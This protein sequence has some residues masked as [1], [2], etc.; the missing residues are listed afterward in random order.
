MTVKKMGEINKGV[1]RK[2]PLSADDSDTDETYKDNKGTE[3]DKENI[4]REEDDDDDNDPKLKKRK[5]R[6]KM[7]MPL[8]N[9]CMPENK[10][11]YCII[12][13]K[14]FDPEKGMN[15]G[16]DE[17]RISAYLGSIDIKY[18]EPAQ[19][20]KIVE[21]FR[22]FRIH[23]GNRARVRII[24]DIVSNAQDNGYGWTCIDD[25]QDAWKQATTASSLD[26][27]ANKL[28]K[29]TTLGRFKYEKNA[30][31][32]YDSCGETTILGTLYGAVERRTD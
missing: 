14:A 21:W 16:I 25:I 1:A 26:S 17:K 30:L 12:S 32:V 15:K 24:Q 18:S 29:C 20:K 31:K 2:N 28:H 6:A 9:G 13:K 5:S 10:K 4:G 11:G 27:V 7:K 22:K 8:D 19:Y 23:L 3:E